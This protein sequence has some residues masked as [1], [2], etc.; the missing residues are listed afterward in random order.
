M[1][2]KRRDDD[3]GGLERAF[4]LLEDALPGL[5][6]VTPP[7]GTVPSGLPEQLIELYAY[8]DGLRMYHDTVEVVPSREVEMPV[9]GRWRFGTVEGDPIAIDIRGKVWRT[10]EELDDDVCDGTRLDRWLS[11]LLDAYGVLYDEEGEFH[12]D[13]FDDEGDLLPKVRDRHLRAYLKRDPSSPGIRWKLAHA[14]LEDGADED[15]RNELEQVVSDDPAFAWAW[16]DLAKISERVGDLGNAIDEIR[17]AAETAEG[18]QHPQAGYFWS[19]LARLAARS[20]DDLLRAEAA[21]KTS[22][23]AP[24]LKRAQLDGARELLETGDTSSAKGLIE[25]LRAVW[26]RDLEVLELAKRV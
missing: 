13:L 6:D 14:L 12:D 18:S 3:L 16:L 24:G 5:H 19:Q 10:D 26:P 25:I 17:M 21:T 4:A 23:L 2:K 7:S 8:C 1:A 15:A 9:P 20:G 22:L 11:G